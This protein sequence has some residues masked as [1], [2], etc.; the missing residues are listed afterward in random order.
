MPYLIRQ[1]FM[2]RKEKRF[3]LSNKRKRFIGGMLAL[4]LLVP[5][6]KVAPVA[7]EGEEN[8]TFSEVMYDLPGG[9]N[10]REWLEIY[11]FGDEAM[12]LNSEDWRFNDGSNHALRLIQGDWNLEPGEAAILTSN[13]QTFLAEHEN[14]NGTVI[15]TVMSLNNAGATLQL[16]ANGGRSFFTSLSYESGWGAGGNG[17]TLEK[18][19][20]AGANERDN[21]R[22]SAV[23]GGTPGAAPEPEEEEQEVFEQRLALRAGWNYVASYVAPEDNSFENIMRPLI[24]RGI[25]DYAKDAAGRIFVP[26]RINQ[27]GTW[28]AGEAYQI[29]IR[30]SGE[31]IIRGAS[32][33][34]PRV[35]LSEGW[36]YIGYLLADQKPVES[37]LVCLSENSVAMVKNQ[38]GKFFLPDYP[39]KNFDFF[40]PGQGYLIKMS[41]AAD[42][43][44]SCLA[45]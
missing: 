26:R 3:M 20:P 8:V 23:D 39:F 32:I 12:E 2:A 17:R 19:D 28:Q 34:E 7:A 1:N 13:D 21:W 37:L 14:F 9:D 38:A 10:N 40:L 5:I 18:A 27:I 6:I 36:N 22:E 42:L 30:R 35:S 15:D 29:K 31:L 44:W 25:F 41:Q 11:N 4:A 43:D 16:S 33:I 24:D 45:D